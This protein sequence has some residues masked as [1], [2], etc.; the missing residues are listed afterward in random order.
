MYETFDDARKKFIHKLKN[1]INEYKDVLYSNLEEKQVLDE[2]KIS[3]DWK[4]RGK[5]FP[6]R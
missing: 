2:K 3:S 4:N 6:I 5:D 1:G